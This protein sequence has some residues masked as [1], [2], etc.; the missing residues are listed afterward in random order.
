M[1]C[2]G[3][4]KST[5]PPKAAAA[6]PSSTSSR[7]RTRSEQGG[8]NKRNV[9]RCKAKR[10][11]NNT[12]HG[13]VDTSQINPTRSN[14]NDKND[15]GLDLL[16]NNNLS[17]YNETATNNN[18]N[19]NVSKSW[20]V[21]HINNNSGDV[22]SSAGS[23]K[24]I[25]SST[26][27]RKSS[28]RRR[29]LV[30][31]QQSKHHT[32]VWIGGGDS[33]KGVQNGSSNYVTKLMFANKDLLTIIPTLRQ[34]AKE[35]YHLCAQAVKQFDKL[36]YRNLEHAIANKL[37]PEIKNEFRE[38]SLE[39][40]DLLGSIAN[41][42]QDLPDDLEKSAIGISL[43]F[44][45]KSS[46]DFINPL[47]PPDKMNPNNCCLKW[48]GGHMIYSALLQA[49]TDPSVLTP[50]MARDFVDQNS[51]MFDAYGACCTGN[52]I[53]PEHP[54]KEVRKKADPKGN[55]VETMEEQL[56]KIAGGELCGLTGSDV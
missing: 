15:Y 32:P 28:R 49:G 22:G 26:S 20:N 46:I 50:Q 8:V 6:A 9:S 29:S 47:F 48:V 55:K 11:T 39:Y 42:G 43:L 13:G 37:A 53:D 31:P 21:T 38:C 1:N 5:T 41:C 18:K 56:E 14:Q 2:V 33:T 27:R 51:S 35:G 7:K 19:N 17:N 16:S 12:N 24:S 34:K 44:G 52:D 36:E 10:L 23:I 25:L 45:I 40:T 4:K 30:A 54:D 3:R